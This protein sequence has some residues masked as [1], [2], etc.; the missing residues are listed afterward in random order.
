MNNDSQR[1]GELAS[2]VSVASEV[3]RV[4]SF[5]FV[6]RRERWKKIVCISR[7]LH[8]TGI[9]RR[10]A[11]S[12]PGD[13]SSALHPPEGRHKNAGMQSGLWERYCAPLGKSL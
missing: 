6:Q 7:W 3:N 12:D 11:T 10:L 5:A 4:G 8:A 1:E 13:Y 2:R 9:N